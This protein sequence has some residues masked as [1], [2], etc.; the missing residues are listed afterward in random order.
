MGVEAIQRGF[1]KAKV[2]EDATGL[3]I[4][5]ENRMVIERMEKIRKNILKPIGII[6]AF[7]KAAL[8]AHSNGDSPRHSAILGVDK[9]E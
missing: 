4:D 8:G 6:N 5:A 3:D 7:K 2:I 1:L 9:F